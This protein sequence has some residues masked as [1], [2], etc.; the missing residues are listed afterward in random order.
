MKMQDNPEHLGKHHTAT[1][2]LCYSQIITQLSPPELLSVASESTS[3]CT[4]ENYDFRNRPFAT[5]D[6][7]ESTVQDF[8]IL[9]TGHDVKKI[10][11]LD[12]SSKAFPFMPGDVI[13]ILPCN[14]HSEVKKLFTR[15]GV[16]IH[17]RKRYKLTIK[18]DTV[19]KNPSMP[20]HIPP[21]GILEDIFLKHL[22][23]RKPMKKAFL[24]VLSKFTQDKEELSYLE[25]LCSPKGSAKY[26]N[27]INQ[28]GRTLLG[29]LNTF[30]KSCPPMELI[31]EHSQALQP[32]F[33]SIST[34]PLSGRLKITFFVVENADGT[35]G[36]CT[37]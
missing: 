28:S 1:T 29:L 24:K 21:E 18:S 35:K 32:R 37:G 34:S 30:P 17:M 33:F 26:L 22:D 8:K 11:E 31:L 2:V 5:S 6:V 36:V 9:T 23:I 20:K 14:S 15:L 27:L 12:L 25:E 10:Y 19:K 13:G 7:F 4:M 16:E 3:L